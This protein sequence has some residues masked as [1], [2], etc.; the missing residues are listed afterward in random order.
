MQTSELTQQVAAKY[1]IDNNLSQ[2][3]AQMNRLYKRKK[4][5]MLKA[6]REAF[7]ASVSYTVPEGGL[8]LWLTFPDG[9][10]SLDIFEKLKDEE[11]VIFVPGDTF[12][13]YGGHPNTARLSFA[14]VSEEEIESGIARM[15][16]FLS[17]YLKAQLQKG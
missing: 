8:F 15:G 16:R 4:D 1:L 9:V 5:L 6:I 14:T 11:R 7:P 17:A 10:D 13:P 3:I 12:Y 2:H